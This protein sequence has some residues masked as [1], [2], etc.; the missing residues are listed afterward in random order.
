MHTTA[1]EQADVEVSE[2]LNDRLFSLMRGIS[3]LP[4]EARF[5]YALHVASNIVEGVGLAGA[6]RIDSRF[7][8]D[9]ILIATQL[10]EMS[11]AIRVETPSAPA[12]HLRLC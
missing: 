4:I 9:L 5:R 2:E 7:L 6:S 11:F 12:S 8:A 10:D 3:D 1:H